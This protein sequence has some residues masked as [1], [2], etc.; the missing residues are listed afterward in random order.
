MKYYYKY[1]GINPQLSSQ[2][3]KREDC[4]LL[5]MAE[6]P[7]WK[8]ERLLNISKRTIMRIQEKIAT[9]DTLKRKEGSRAPRK[10]RKEHQ[11]SISKYIKTNP[12]LSCTDIKNKL[13]LPFSEATVRRY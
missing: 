10:I 12:F 7:Y 6:V 9:D 4:A 11:L 1:M 13:E 5:L 8:I 3:R 2:E